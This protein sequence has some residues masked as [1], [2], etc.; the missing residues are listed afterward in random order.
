MSLTRRVMVVGAAIFA[1][2]KA[3]FAQSR[4]DIPGQQIRTFPTHA[5]DVSGMQLAGWMA[6]VQYRVSVGP[7]LQITREA[8]NTITIS[9]PQQPTPPTATKFL[10]GVKATST[11]LNKWIAVAPAGYVNVVAV[12]RNGVRQFK[13]VDYAIDTLTPTAIAALFGP[14]EDGALVQFDLS[15]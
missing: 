9:A 2:S 6:G 5:G 15:T 1:A 8:G 11:D 3:L 12:Y 10:W 7:G 14:W 4:T 13:D